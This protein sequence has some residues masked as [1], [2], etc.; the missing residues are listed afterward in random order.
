MEMDEGRHKGGGGGGGGGLLTPVPFSPRSFR[1]LLPS[2]LILASS[3][4]LPVRTKSR[5]TFGRAGVEF[6]RACPCRPG[7]HHER[8]VRP[9]S[10]DR[11][12]WDSPS[13]A[14]LGLLIGAKPRQSGPAKGLGGGGGGEGWGGPR[15]S[16]VSA[17]GSPP[18]VL[19]C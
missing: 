19:R 7:G 3:L 17:P 6:P 13:G 5:I 10:A 18:L 9:L 2:P 16:D 8:L 14:A 12:K 11:R 15:P 1:S 4:H